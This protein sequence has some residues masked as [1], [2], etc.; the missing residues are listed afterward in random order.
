LERTRQKHRGGEAAAAQALIALGTAR[1]SGY[2]D[3]G[4]R[5]EPIQHE[6]AEEKAAGL[7][8]A[9]KRLVAAL[10]AY[11][12]NPAGDENRMAAARRERVVWEL[13]ESLTSFVV[14]REACGLRDARHVFDVYDVPREAVA[15][16]GIRRP[17]A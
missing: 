10:E 17:R 13:V 15:R 2:A 11:R 9:E 14:Q 12:R 3:A 7:G 6:I 16:M 8:R 4:M 5:A 1:D